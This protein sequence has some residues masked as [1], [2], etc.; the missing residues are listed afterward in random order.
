VAGA[1]AYV[2]IFPSLV[3]YLLYNAAVR[4]LGAGRAGQMLTLMPLF[5]ALLAAVLLSEPLHAYHLTGMVLIL[6]GIALSAWRG[7][8][9]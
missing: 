1:F 9:H 2:A 6:G 3:G 7:R 5:G 4:D 8:S